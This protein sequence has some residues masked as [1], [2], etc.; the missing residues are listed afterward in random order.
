MR[1]RYVVVERRRASSRTAAVL[2]VDTHRWAPFIDARGAQTAADNLNSNRLK[3][4]DYMG[5]RDDMEQ[6]S[7][8]L[9]EGDDHD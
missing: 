2:D 1:E 8:G 3:G 7:P 4:D 9:R 6:T 5:W